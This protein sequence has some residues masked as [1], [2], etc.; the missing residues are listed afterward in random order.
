MATAAHAPGPPPVSVTLGI[1]ARHLLCF[2]L[3]LLSLSF[4]LT[5]PH[6]WAIALLW[7]PPLAILEQ[8][9][10][11]SPLERRQPHVALPGWPFDTIVYLH[12]GLHLLNLFL[13][14]RLFVVQS[15]WSVDALMCLVLVGGNSGF[16]GIVVAHELIHR[17]SRAMRLLGRAILCTV[18]YEH[19]YTEH[20]RGHHVR[21]GTPADPATARFGETF[22]A[23]YLRTVP[24]QFRSAWRLDR[25]AVLQGL[26]AEWALAFVVWSVFGWTSFVMYVLQGVRASFLLEV[27]NYFEHWGLVR[28]GGPSGRRVRTVDSWDTDSWMTLYSLVGLSRHADHHAHAARPYQ[29]LRYHEE[30]P[31]LP[32][33]YLSIVPRVL[34]RNR[35]F[36]KQATAELERRELGPFAENGPAAAG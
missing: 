21:V 6:S 14:V 12:A 4:L 17:R 18:L 3:P 35:T 2:S 26:A 8:L 10:R 30:S 5:A 20:V 7:I 16:S 29:Q 24:A 33:G 28:A 22:R 1:W 13:L 27:V 25:T 31:K 32:L 36:I 11:R 19:F 23:F 9:D 15:L 34:A